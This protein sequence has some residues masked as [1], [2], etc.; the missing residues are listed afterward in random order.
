[1]CVRVCVCLPSPQNDY[2]YGNLLCKLYIPENIS[3]IIDMNI[4]FREWHLVWHIC[5][6][7]LPHTPMDFPLWK[8]DFGWWIKSRYAK[9][10]FKFE[11]ISQPLLER[12]V[13]AEQPSVLS[14][15]DDLWI[16]LL[17]TCRYSNDMQTF[18]SSFGPATTILP[19]ESFA[20][21]TIHQKFKHLPER[22][23]PWSSRFNLVFGF[24]LLW[25]HSAIRI[26]LTNMNFNLS[27]FGPAVLAA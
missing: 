16:W 22:F 20:W 10:S 6:W 8:L 24:G 23:T 27:S 3:R 15:D 19:L 25:L 11:A 1:M 4:T 21:F 7:C 26:V 9:C 14:P 17:R 2:L 12:E 5:W 13:V 18:F